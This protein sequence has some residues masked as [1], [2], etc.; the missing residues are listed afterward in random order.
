MPQEAGR[1]GQTL[2]VATS[3]PSASRRRKTS[4]DAAIPSRYGVTGASASAASESWAMADGNGSSV[5]RS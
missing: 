5:A 1:R 3:L 2:S 4:A